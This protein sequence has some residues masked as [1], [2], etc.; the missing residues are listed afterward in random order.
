MTYRIETYEGPLTKEILNIYAAVGWTNYTQ[1]TVQLSA[2]FAQ[3][4]KILVA[5]QADQ[6]LG[7]VRV[8]GDGQTI[9]FIQDLLVH[10]DFQRQGIGCALVRQILADYASVYQIHLLTDQTDKT[11]MFYEQL[12]FQSVEKVACRAFTFTR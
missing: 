12:G 9:I 6:I 10:P 5:K 3:S 1:N 11:K 2:G 8:V 4:L 7:L